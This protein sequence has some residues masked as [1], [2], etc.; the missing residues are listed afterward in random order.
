MPRQRGFRTGSKHRR[1]AGASTSTRRSRRVCFAEDASQG[2]SIE[3]PAKISAALNDAALDDAV[4]PEALYRRPAGH[5]LCC[6]DGNS[7]LCR[8]RHCYA[9]EIGMCEPQIYFNAKEA[10][11]EEGGAVMGHTSYGVYFHTFGVAWFDLL[12][13]RV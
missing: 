3:P 2:K 10:R 11:W 12:K 6:C 7:I 5:E 4:Q 1:P 8:I 13:V 9:S